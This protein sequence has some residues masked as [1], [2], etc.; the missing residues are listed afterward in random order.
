M[1]MLVDGTDILTPRQ[2]DRCTRQLRSGS[3]SFYVASRMLPARVQ[4]PASALYAFC[5]VADDLIDLS[6]AGE[7]GLAQARERLDAAYRGTTGQDTVDAAFS[8]VVKAFAIPRELP[9][10]LMEG[11]EWDA[12]GRRYADL[13][14]L[15]AYAARVAGS[16]GAMCAL[17]MGVRTP[18]ILARACE[19]GVAMQLTNIARDVGEDAAAGRLYL[20]EDWMREA[21]IDPE[22]WLARPEFSPAL[23][24]VVQRLLDTAERL[25]RS[26][27]AGIAALPPSCR[28]GIGTARFVYAEIGREVERRRCDSVSSRATVGPLRKAAAVLRSL[29]RSHWLDLAEPPLAEVGF[30]VEAVQHAAPPRASRS[31][32][33]RGIDPVGRIVWTMELFEK[34]EQRE[35]ADRF[36]QGSRAARMTG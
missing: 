34:L 19:L 16:V 1:P 31:G 17:L 23:G 32:V 15:Y 22:A 2:L 30:L 4:R 25:Y 8:S 35:T 7:D 14:D 6:D 33:S 13:S 20:P 10:A 11:F 36:R 18:L 26:A 12:A 24:A 29:T 5:R 28:L 21:G 27:E 3:R 9:D